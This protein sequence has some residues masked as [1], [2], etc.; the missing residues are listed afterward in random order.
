M[1]DYKKAPMTVANFV[2]L[3]EG[4]LQ[5]LPTRRERHFIKDRSGTEL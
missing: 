2:G 1:L 3:A 5:M 4:T